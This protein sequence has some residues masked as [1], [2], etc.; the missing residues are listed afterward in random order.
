[1]IAIIDYQ[2]GNLKSVQKS[3]E[4]IGFKAKITNDS[5][6]IKKAKGLVIPGVGAFDGAIKNLH[7]MGMI[8]AIKDFVS[9]GKPLL[10]I[11]LGMQLLMTTSEE[12]GLHRGLDL[13]PGEVL[14]LPSKVK[15]PHMGW[16]S[17]GL[18]KQTLLTGKIEKGSYF[19]FVHSYYVKPQNTEHIV[20]TTEYGIEF[21]S[22]I[23]K[24]NIMGVQFHPE[25]SSYLGQKILINFGEMI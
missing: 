16:N 9:S 21:C 24:E 4:G 5:K 17:L 8:S 12:N 22:I 18:Q 23:E 14:R 10:G 15:I 3:F 2:M 6:I 1:M 20:A 19:Y 25:K 11:C 7:E 13:I